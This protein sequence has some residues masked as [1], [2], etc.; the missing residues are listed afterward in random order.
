MKLNIKTVDYMEDGDFMLI[1]NGVDAIIRLDGTNKEVKYPIKKA[2]F[3]IY[4][5]G[6]VFTDKDLEN[7]NPE[8]VKPTEKL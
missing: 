8:P 4:R 6:K 7:F 2:T 3:G 1:Q 5:K